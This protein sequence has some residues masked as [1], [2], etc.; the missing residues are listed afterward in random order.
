MFEEIVFWHWFGVAAV[1]MAME[2]LAPG[3]FLLWIGIA[4]AI[5]GVVLLALPELSLQW[6]L[7]A[8]SVL[9]VLAVVLSRKFI[10]RSDSGTT[11]PA[12]NQRTMRYVGQTVTLETAIEGG[13]GRATVGDSSWIVSGPDLPIGSKVKIVGSDGAVLRVE[14]A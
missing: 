1:L 3:A 13:R 9:A 12:L 14:K 8:F 7:L 4:S 11:D 10:K 6:Q 2:M 5:T